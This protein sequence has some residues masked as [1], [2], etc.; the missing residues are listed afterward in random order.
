M[1]SESKSNIKFNNR[2]YPE[3]WQKYEAYLQD[4]SYLEYLAKNI[5]SVK[6]AIVKGLDELKDNKQEFPEFEFPVLDQTEVIAELKR[7]NKN[8][9]EL[10]EIQLDTNE[11]LKQLIEAMR[12]F[13]FVK[14]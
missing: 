11:H 5:E 9:A 6:E 7:N 2:H 13:S 4:K 8:I 3:K 14:K 1:S 12:S 10:L